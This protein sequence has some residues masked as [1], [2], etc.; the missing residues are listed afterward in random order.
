MSLLD[1]KE[2][3]MN[4]ITNTFKNKGLK[5]TPQRI[6]VYEYL[7]GTKA[8]PSAETIYTALIERFPTMSLATVYKSL[9][10]LCQV[11]LVQELNLGEGNFRYDALMEEHGHFQCTCCHQ[12]FDLLHLPKRTIE[13]TAS[14]GEDFLISSSKLY[15]YGLCRAC[16]EEPRQ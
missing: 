5:L 1:I 7:L 8:H 3:S 16:Q 12:V 6:A 9:K 11:N 4:S 14:L 13:E 2:N 15:F 10:T